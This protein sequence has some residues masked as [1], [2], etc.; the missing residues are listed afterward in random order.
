MWPHPDAPCRLQLQ[1]QQ[2][3]QLHHCD[4]DE[5]L[6]QPWRSPRDGDGHA[7]HDDAGHQQPQHRSYHS[8]HTVLPHHHQQQQQH[9]QYDHW[10]PAHPDQRPGTSLTM[11]DLSFIEGEIS[12]LQ[13]QLVNAQ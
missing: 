7:S 2:H 13:R 8:T 6:A 4:N 1:L 5:L 9:Q 3:Q 11:A 10:L 12:L